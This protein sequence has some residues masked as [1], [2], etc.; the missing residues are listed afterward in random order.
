MSDICIRKSD[1][2]S[3][4]LLIDERRTSRA[5][6]ENLER[7]ES[8]LNRARLVEDDDLPDDVVALDADVTVRDLASGTTETYRLVM[9]A[10][11]DVARNRISVLAPIGAAL[12]G[13]AVDDQITW[14]VPGGVRTLR[15]EN[16]EHAAALRRKQEGRS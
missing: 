13:Y 12:L 4:E 16:V 14:P 11:A 8:E 3:I 15:I 9:P 1:R 7:L 10:K 5:D 6:R 2:H